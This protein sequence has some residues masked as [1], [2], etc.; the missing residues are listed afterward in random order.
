MNDL[1]AEMDDLIM[2]MKDCIS[3][4]NNP[5]QQFGPRCI[6]KVQ[7]KQ[8]M[9]ALLASQVAAARIDTIEYCLKYPMRNDVVTELK[10]QLAELQEKQNE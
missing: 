6:T 8:Q 1:E 7:F 9:K 4:E 2:R 3:H 10:K 5:D